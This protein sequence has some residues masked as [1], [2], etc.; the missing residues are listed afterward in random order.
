MNTSR[1][2]KKLQEKFND[3]L[4][5]FVGKIEEAKQNQHEILENFEKFQSKEKQELDRVSQQ[6]KS[7]EETMAVIQ[8]AIN[9]VDQ[10]IQSRDKAI[11]I[12]KEEI[13]KSEETAKSLIENHKKYINKVHKEIND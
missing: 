1:K 5:I 3:T 4:K 11:A 12:Q 13:E 8:N 10:Q 6:I 9:L 7:K 2:N